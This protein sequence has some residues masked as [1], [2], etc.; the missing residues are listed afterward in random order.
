MHRKY[1]VQ[2]RNTNDL[3]TGKIFTCLLKLAGPMFVGA[4]L[5][6]LQSLID[7]FWVGKLGSS[8][9]AALAMSG[10]ILMLLFPIVMGAATG[11]VA[12][13]SRFVGA[14][15]LDEASDTAGQSLLVALL[16]GVGT[17]L[18]G[19]FFA[20]D[21]C[22]LLGADESVNRLARDYLGISF[23][24]CFT[25][26]VLFIG[27]SALQGAGNTIL[28][29]FAMLLANI[30]NIVLDPILIY[31]L[32]GFPRM[33]VRGAAWATLIAQAAAAG[34]VV[35][36]LSRGVAG[37]HVR[38]SRWRLQPALV[39]TLMRIGLPSSGQ[40]LSRSLM[41]LILMRIVALCGTAAIAGYGIGMRFHMIIL[42]PA[43][44][45]GNAAATMVGQNLGAGR[46]D[47][48]RS[49]AWLATG[50]DVMIMAVS[51]A[52]MLA[53]AP[54]FVR[55]FDANPEVVSVG[56]NYLR[57]VSP[58]YIFTAL[59]IVLGRAL[60]GAGQTM[61]TMICTVA[62]VWGL[63]VPLAIFLSR[64]AQPATQGIWWAIAIAVT[65]HGLMVT[66]WFLTGRWKTH[67]VIVS[68]FPV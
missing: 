56:A 60:D 12:M 45:L 2:Q 31:G 30:I 42:I 11:T 16:I 28:P 68:R 46:P 34:L 65:V 49:A 57:T 40:M 59:A 62:S 63:Q 1:T 52:L 54:P 58:F 35:V 43:F 21:L 36:F 22:R 47:R 27:N 13:V 18:I 6:N 50:I 61:A 39:W 41:A 10:T 51:A 48:S 55:L 20:A 14:G 44:V 64:V 67:P 9:V 4:L 29:M 5:Q 38:A 19:W 26:F 32:L 33:G 66:G 23:L 17:G 7:L 8:A 15:R 24:G 3:T 25:V 53:F 37:L